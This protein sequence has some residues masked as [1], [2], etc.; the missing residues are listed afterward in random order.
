MFLQTL[1]APGGVQDK[2]RAQ[3]ELAAGRGMDPVVV[4]VEPAPSGLC[5]I[6]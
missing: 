6:R 3:L 2:L 5:W 1:L 4:I